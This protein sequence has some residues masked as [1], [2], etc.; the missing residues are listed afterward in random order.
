MPLP[1][2]RLRTR[3][4]PLPGNRVLRLGVVLDDDGEPQTV[5]IGAGYDSDSPLMVLAQG[6]TLPATAL[7]A[8]RAALDA[9]EAT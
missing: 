3:S 6:A 8:L 1:E 4:V 2:T 7:G 9:L 5:H